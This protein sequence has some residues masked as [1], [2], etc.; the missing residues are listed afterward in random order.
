MVFCVG[1]VDREELAVPMP[2]RALQF[3]PHARFNIV[4]LPCDF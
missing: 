4:V 3:H 1:G 2:V